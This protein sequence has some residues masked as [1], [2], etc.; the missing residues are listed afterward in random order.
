MS[1]FYQLEPEAAGE[2]GTGSVIDRGVRPPK[3]EYLE[4]TLSGWLGDCLIES[5]P[6]YMIT[7][8]AANEL[9]TNLHNGFKIREAQITISPSVMDL[10]PEADIPEF[11][12]LEVFG[13]P[14]KN[15]FGIKDS[16]LIVSNSAFQILKKH[17]LKNCDVVGFSK[18]SGE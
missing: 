3:V 18:R 17:G 14:F 5:Y 9:T 11:R 13:T 7:L 1:E 15:D 10:Y 8:M 6:V 16:M 4:Y 2:V 12:W